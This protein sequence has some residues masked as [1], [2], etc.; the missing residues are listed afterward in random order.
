MIWQHSQGLQHFGQTFESSSPLTEDPEFIRS[1]SSSAV[2][3]LENFSS[4]AKFIA[5]LRTSSS[6]YFFPM[7]YSISRRYFFKNLKHCSLAVLLLFISFFI[8]LKYFLLKKSST[9]ILNIS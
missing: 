1:S 8:N 9:I 2:L 3:E 5:S 6:R 7:R 4:I